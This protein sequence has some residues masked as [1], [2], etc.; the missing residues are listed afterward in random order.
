MLDAHT[1]GIRLTYSVGR[2]DGFWDEL[3]QLRELKVIRLS[4]PLFLGDDS[5]VLDNRNLLWNKIANLAE[6]RVSHFTSLRE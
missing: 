2:Y 3:K 6:H 5:E 4:A 1:V